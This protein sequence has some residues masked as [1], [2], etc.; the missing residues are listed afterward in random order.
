MTALSR[1]MKNMTS[2]KLSRL[3]NN[4]LYCT[5]HLI[6][7]HTLLHTNVDALQGYTSY[8]LLLPCLLDLPE[9]FLQ[10]LPYLA[11]HNGSSN[12]LFYYWRNKCMQVLP[13]ECPLQ[14]FKWKEV[15]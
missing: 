10:C 15:I 11:K 12:F 7:Q 5:T 3:G 1:K 2:P 8:T 6:T 9:P 4:T 13:I 14:L